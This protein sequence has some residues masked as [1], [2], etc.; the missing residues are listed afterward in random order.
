MSKRVLIVIGV[1]LVV[2]AVGMVMSVKRSLKAAASRD[3]AEMGEPK[4]P[5][6]A[7]K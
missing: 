4:A 2:V 1:I 5:P 3:P 7:K 6:P